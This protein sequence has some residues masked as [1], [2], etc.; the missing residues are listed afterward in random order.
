MTLFNKASHVILVSDIN[1]SKE[2][3]RDKLGFTI[4]GQFVERDGVSFLLKEIENKDLIRP[5]H[6]INGFMESYLWVDDVDKIY[7]ELKARGA[8]V[9]QPINRDYGMRDFLLYDIDGYRF[10]LGG[11]IKTL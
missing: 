10:C 9:E 3:Y 2:Y 6:S 8:I 5:N 4:D 7:E 11:P 1:K